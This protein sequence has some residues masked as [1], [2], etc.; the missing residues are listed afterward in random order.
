MSCESGLE[1]DEDWLDMHADSGGGLC[2]TSLRCVL[3]LL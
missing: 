3:A 1:T 2:L